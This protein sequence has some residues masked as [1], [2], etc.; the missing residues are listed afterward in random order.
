MFKVPLIA[1]AI[2]HAT[3]V[4][5]AVV[6]GHGPSSSAPSPTV[7]ISL[8]TLASQPAQAA[9]Q[10]EEAPPVNVAA[11][12]P[13]HVHSHIH[14][15][16]VPVDH[17]RPHDPSLVHE[18]THDHADEQPSASE[19]SAIAVAAPVAAPVFNMVIGPAIAAH[20]GL[21]AAHPTP[22][23]S[24]LAEPMS[25][26]SV[27]VAARLLTSAPPVYP[28]AARAAE[29]E[30]DVVVDLVLDESG[31]VSEAKILRAAGFDLDKSALEAIRGY[32]F[33]PAQKDGRP[34]RVRMHWTVQFRLR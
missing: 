23:M 1:S 3:I 17:D 8:E 20:G 7:E 25:E 5:V 31:R 18:H 10:V 32:R 2:V 30:A 33:S 11:Q 24:P 19:A 26:G 15:Y 34:V 6:G 14:D 28:P 22:A 9:A 12:V 4:A 13:A 16:P 27:N 21:T 29:V